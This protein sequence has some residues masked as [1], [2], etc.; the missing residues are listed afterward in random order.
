MHIVQHT[1]LK[2]CALLCIILDVFKKNLALAFK[3][4]L[5]ILLG[6]PSNI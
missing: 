4:L 1:S 6:F 2:H 5:Y 3:V